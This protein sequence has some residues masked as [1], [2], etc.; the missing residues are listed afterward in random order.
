MRV[1]VSRSED[2]QAQTLRFEHKGLFLSV[3]IDEGASWELLGVALDGLARHAHDML[4]LYAQKGR[5]EK[6]GK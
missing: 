5:L 6:E 2:W 3:D 4:S 1:T